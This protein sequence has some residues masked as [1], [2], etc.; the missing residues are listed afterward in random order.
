MNN[1]ILII[2]TSTL[3]SLAVITGIVAKAPFNLMD[4]NYQE[5]VVSQG[6]NNFFYQNLPDHKFDRIVSPSPDLLYNFMAYD[7]TNA[8]VQITFPVYSGF[9]V[10]QFISDQTDSFAYMDY[11][12][13]TGQPQSAILYAKGAD[14]SAFPQSAKLIQ[15]PSNTGVVLVRYLVKDR[16]ELDEIDGVRKQVSISIF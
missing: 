7:V 8:S 5:M 4:K 13:E 1:K 11:K 14:T 16:A 15:A 3:I 2:V 6:V 9:W 12:N 10:S